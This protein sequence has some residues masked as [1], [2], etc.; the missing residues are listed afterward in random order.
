RLDTALC[1]DI[2][3]LIEAHGVGAAHK[4]LDHLVELL[5]ALEFAGAAEQIVEYDGRPQL[6]RRG[7]LRI[8]G[9]A[10]VHAAAPHHGPEIAL[11]LL[12]ILVM[13]TYLELRE[14]FPA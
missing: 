9:D 7:P 13:A 12:R 10:Q 11:Q 5:P 4:R 3:E 8:A 14:V 2:A 6:A 1:Q